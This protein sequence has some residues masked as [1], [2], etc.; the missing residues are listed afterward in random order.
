M[1][2]ILTIYAAAAGGILLS[3]VVARVV[4][5]FGPWS[6]AINVFVSK[7]FAYP[8]ALDRH[9]L[10]GPWTRAGILMHLTYVT[11]NIFLVIF[12]SPALKAA[13]NR[14][15]TLSLI[16][17]VFLVASLYLSNTADL[18]GISLKN[19]RRIHRATG[20]ML[21]ALVLFHIAAMLINQKRKDLTESPRISFAI[22]VR[23]NL[24]NNYTANWSLGCG[25]P[26]RPGGSII[27]PHPKAILRDFP[28]RPPSICSR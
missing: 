21:S 6:S 14:A 27:G 17:I 25:M 3:V 2:Q 28:P 8:Y 26:G 24:L 18:L 13:G 7:H 23:K 5:K 11:L 22:I 4:S 12:K 19:C 9:K 15:G 1:M 10:L 20:W 16:N